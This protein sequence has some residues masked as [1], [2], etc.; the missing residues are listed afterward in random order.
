MPKALTSAGTLGSACLLSAPC[1]LHAICP[2]PQE[3]PGG[4]AAPLHRARDEWTAAMPRRHSGAPSGHPHTLGAR[5]GPGA[6]IPAQANMVPT[7]TGPDRHLPP[8]RL[9]SHTAGSPERPTS[10]AHSGH[11]CTQGSPALVI[12]S[13]ARR[14]AEH[15]VPADATLCGSQQARWRPAGAALG[16]RESTTER[17]GSSTGNDAA[18]QGGAGRVLTT[19]ETKQ[20]Q[21]SELEAEHFRV[22]LTWR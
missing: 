14:T 5:V 6:P 17:G 12:Y 18:S 13:R 15:Q 20:D 22:K 8:R 19:Q 21:P 7:G 16:G 3:G 2:H 1:S 11:L 9:S 4:H 10:L